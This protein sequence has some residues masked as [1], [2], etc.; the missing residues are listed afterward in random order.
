MSQNVSRTKGHAKVS[1]SAVSKTPA[2]LKKNLNINNNNN[3]NHHST[4]TAANSSS[5][6]HAK[7]AATLDENHNSKSE[8]PPA[9]ATA[10]P[11]QIR[12]AQLLGTTNRTEDPEIN[13]KIKQV[14]RGH[15]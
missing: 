5:S 6:H 9:S 10:T 12:L 14:S 3:N 7:S 2:E 4:N 15:V 13:K 8:A 11:E 1:T